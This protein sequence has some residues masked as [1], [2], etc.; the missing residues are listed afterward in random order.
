MAYIPLFLIVSGYFLADPNA[1]LSASS[2]YGILWFLN[3]R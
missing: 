3:R 2:I 1:G